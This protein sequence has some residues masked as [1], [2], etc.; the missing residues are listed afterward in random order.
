MKT[1]AGDTLSTESE[2]ATCVF[3]FTVIDLVFVFYFGIKDVVIPAD[4]PVWA[5]ESG[6]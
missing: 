4:L 3:K 1:G 5:V 2:A 6:F